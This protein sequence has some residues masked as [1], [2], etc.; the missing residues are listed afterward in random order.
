MRLRDL[1]SP[2]HDARPGGGAAAI[3]TLVLHYTGMRSGAEAI[4]R[5]RDPAARVSAHYVVE[6]DGAVFRLVPEER[7]AWHAGV[8][9]WRGR[10][11][12]NATSIGIEVVNPGHAWGYRPFPALQ[13]AAVCDLCLEVLARHPGI[14]PPGVVA[15]SDIA[16]D[17]KEDPGELFDWAG[18]AAN[19]V[20]LWPAGA[21]PGGLGARP[22]APTPD[23]AEAEA[24]GALA[25]IGYRPDLPLPVLLAAFQRHWRPARVDGALDAGTL[26]RLRA[27]AAACEAGPPPPRHGG[28]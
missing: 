9:R 6:E 5:L 25:A 20:G 1:P 10:E 24:R 16:P 13:M 17:R 11:G 4:A 2:N 3:D 15:H 19:G 7:R 8:S 22:A 21:E 12:L 28:G 18:L 27:V 23:G 14:A 26:A